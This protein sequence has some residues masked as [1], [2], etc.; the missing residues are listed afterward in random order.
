MQVM[1]RMGE[2]GARG[3]GRAGTRSRE[4]GRIARLDRRWAR[5]RFTGVLRELFLSMLLTPMIDLYV[6]RRARGRELF[7]ELKGPVIIV[8]NHAS[9]IDTPVILRALPRRW[10]GRTTVAAAAD[11]FYRNRLVAA[12]VSF[13]FN[14][15]PI[16]RGG[17]GLDKDATTHLHRLLR[18]RWNLL[19]YPEGTRSRSG[20]PGRLRSGAARLAAEHGLPI[21]PVF[22]K[23]T[24]T[25]LPPGR[26][27]PD[28]ARTPFGRRRRH[29][30][31]VRFGRPIPPARS[32][33]EVRDVTA[34]V[35]AFFEAEGELAGVVGARDG[36]A[37]AVRADARVVR[38]GA[39]VREAPARDSVPA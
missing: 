18:Q 20:A 19:L 25:V 5:W 27:W 23:G 21:V 7:A 3:A 24:S 6:R 12:A 15:V 10:R 1:E 38:A 26:F 30:V 14:T 33:E 28:W 32:S 22:I 13:V 31:E 2:Q 35:R 8:A 17:G 11:Y 9:H 37:D 29:A 39:V 4:L 36:D 34:L 16:S